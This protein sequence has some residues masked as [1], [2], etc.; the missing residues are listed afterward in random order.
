MTDIKVDIPILTVPNLN[1][2]NVNINIINVNCQFGFQHSYHIHQLNGKKENSFSPERP[3]KIEV[4]F[5]SSWEADIKK[6]N[7][8]VNKV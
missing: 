4:T 5:N 3:K 2:H 6:S 8:E 7:A 1:D